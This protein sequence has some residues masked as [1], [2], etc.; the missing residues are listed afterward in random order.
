MKKGLILAL[1]TAFVAFAS[2]N[3]L[4][5]SITQSKHN[6]SSTSGNWIR[7]TTATGSGGE[8]CVFC[9]SPHASQTPTLL[10]PLW[11]HVETTVSFSLYTSSTF[12]GPNQTQ[13][14]G[15]TKACLSC[16]DGV[17]AVNNII[18]NDESGSGT[19]PAMQNLT[20]GNALPPTLTTYIGT[21]L[22]KT[23]PV[24]FDYTSSHPDVTSGDLWNPS[25]QNVPAGWLSGTGTIQVRALR[26][27]K[28]ECA[29]CHEPHDNVNGRFLRLGSTTS[30]CL[31]CHNK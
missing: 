25:T 14:G 16:H 22:S 21:D 1:V 2:A 17:T 26:N 28:V 8:I 23:H 18:N 9:H 12:N 10:I 15:A 7:A 20:A 30:L 31:T 5:L 27:N 19:D 11:N 13:P 6:L 3:A 24:S 4:A 29:S